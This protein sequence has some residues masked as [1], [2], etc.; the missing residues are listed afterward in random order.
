MG[1]EYDGVIRSTYIIDPK[2]MI[3]AGWTK[4]RVKEHSKIV[5]QKLQELKSA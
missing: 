4:V 2:G 5:M 1:K 3:V